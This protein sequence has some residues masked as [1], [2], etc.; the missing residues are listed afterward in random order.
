MT[1]TMKR[2]RATSARQDAEANAASYNKILTRDHLHN[3]DPM[4]LLRNT[5]PIER[6]VFTKRFLDKHLISEH[7]ARLFIKIM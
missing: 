6:P 3:L 5:H 7:E 2:T 4:Q 1:T